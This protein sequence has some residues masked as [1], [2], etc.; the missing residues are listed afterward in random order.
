MKK[1]RVFGN[2]DLPILP[3]TRAVLSIMGYTGIASSLAVRHY[4]L[5]F[6]VWD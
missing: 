2:L 3:E 5:L 1:K 4:V 6:F